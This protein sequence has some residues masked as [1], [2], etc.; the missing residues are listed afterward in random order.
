MGTPVEVTVSQAEPARANEAVETAF[1]E[2][3]RV[4]V[5]M[6]HYRP[7]SE[8][9]RITRYA[10][11]KE[12]HVSPQTLAVIDRALEFSRVS[13]GAFDV[14]IGPAFRTWNF[15]D[16]KIPDDLTRKESLKRVDYRKVLVDRGKS[17]VFL[18]DRGME[19]DLGAIAKGYAVD[20]A[21]A[22]LLKRGI[23]NFLVKAGGEIKTHGEKARGVPW[24]I[25]IQHP[26]LPSEF[27]AKLRVRNG[28]IS[29]SGDYERF[30]LK[31]GRRYHH[32]LNAS[33]GMPAEECQS[34]TIMAP[35]SMDGDALSTTV[36][37][38]GPEK[39]LALIEKMPNVHAIIVN[40]RG[41]VLISPGWPDGVVSPP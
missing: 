20:L 35:E 22:A 32:I 31:E 29:T 37:V 10:G 19:L 1:R 24:V 5:L 34:V 23:E 39:G 2:V 8:V 28:A 3:E 15:R 41:I 18:Q 13:A 11:Q 6:S 36:F 17:S 12:I 16:G 21:C 33:T 7:D 30:F 27:V 4:D 40:R 25:G 38:L 9:S 14:T 26:R